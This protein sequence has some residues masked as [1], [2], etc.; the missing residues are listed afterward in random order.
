MRRWFGIGSTDGYDQFIGAWIVM[1]VRVITNMRG[2]ASTQY[3]GVDF[4][5]LHDTSHG[6]RAVVATFVR[7]FRYDYI[8]LNGAL[9]NALLLAILKSFVPFHRTKL[10]LLDILLS[11]PVG[12][13]GRIKAWLI[14]RLLKRVHKIMLYYNN[15][16]GLQQHFGIPAAKFLY[17]PFK[18]NQLEMISLMTPVDGGYVFCG[19]KTRRDFDTLFEAVKGLDCPVKLVTTDN[20]DIAQHGS[21]VD[22]RTA[23]PNVEV[24]RLDGSPEAFISHMASARVVVLPIKPD[25]CG[26]GI[27]V[28]IMAMA[29]KKCVIISSGPGAEDVLSSDQAI[30]VPACDPLSLREAIARAFNDSIYRRRYEEQGFNYA[31]PL[32]GEV[33][34]LQSIIKALHEDQVK[35][36]AASR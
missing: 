9:H 31:W 7:S 10:V 27:G 5:F 33:R 25:I 11:T 28:Y 34:L 4:E 15:T 20:R 19:G 36:P 16:K 23:P 12:F 21:Y 3:N 26:A 35:S 14:G 29:L 18:I 32:R 6:I 2:L 22:E 17:V 24:V 1:K 13:K 8:L 30:I